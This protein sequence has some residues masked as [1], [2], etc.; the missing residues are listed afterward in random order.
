M[1]ATSIGEGGALII[2]GAGLKML[3]DFLVARHNANNQKTTVSPPVS[4]RFCI[5]P[6]RAAFFCA[7]P[8]F[9]AFYRLL[10]CCI[11]PLSVLLGSVGGGADGAAG[12]D[13]L[14]RRS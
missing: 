3:F 2:S 10:P 5:K 8:W 13:D 7:T 12:F 1:D 14:Y 9:T 4:A 6:D 11:K